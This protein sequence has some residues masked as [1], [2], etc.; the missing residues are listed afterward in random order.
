LNTDLLPIM[1][2]NVSV[3]TTVP[4]TK[5][6]AF[7]AGAGYYPKGYST[8]QTQFFRDDKTVFT[9][10]TRLQFLSIPLMA[11]FRVYHTD[12]GNQVWVDGGMNYD[13]FL[14]GNTTY[15]FTTFQDGVSD[16]KVHYT[17]NVAGRFSPSKYSPTANTWDVNGLDVAWKLQL[18]YI[19]HDKYTIMLYHMNS[20]YDIR[21]D[22]GDDVTSSIKLRYTGISVGYTLF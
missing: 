8:N 14:H 19:W 9:S 21:A 3:F 15:D 7:F 2:P 12:A 13:I 1:R 6:I 20:L 11:S 5:S 16:N 22:I 18:R 17:V 4:I 10:G